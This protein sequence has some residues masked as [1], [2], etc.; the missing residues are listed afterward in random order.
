MICPYFSIRRQSGSV[1]RKSDF[2]LCATAIYLTPS[3]PV[4]FQ[5]S[6]ESDSDD[7]E[8]ES[9]EGNEGEE[10][11]EDDEEDVEESDTQPEE[12]EKSSE[13]VCSAVQSPGTSGAQ[14][15]RTAEPS[16]AAT[17]SAGE[18]SGRL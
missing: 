14:A 1:N 17:K 12:P 9:E 8:A 3:V 13:G 6:M 2:L 10:D 16:T 11:A 5:V 7:D 15:Q 18:E 4:L